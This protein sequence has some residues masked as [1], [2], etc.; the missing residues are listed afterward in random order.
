MRLR[1]L[2]T[3]Y[4]RNLPACRFCKVAALLLVFV[5]SSCQLHAQSSPNKSSGAVS[6]SG[7]VVNGVTHEP[8]GRALV[9]SM[10]E[11]YAALTDDHG[12]FELTLPQAFQV[13]FQVRRPGSFSGLKQRTE[14]TVLQ[15]GQSNVTLWLIPEGL[16]VGKVKF[17]NSEAGDKVQVQ[18]YSREV[19]NGFAQWTPI[20]RTTT[21]SNGEFRFA[22]LRAGDY[23]LFTLEELEQD[24][25]VNLPS[26]P[27]YGFPPRFF[28]AAKSFAAAETIHLQPGQTI[29]ADIS[30]ERQRYYDVRVPVTF[31]QPADW[32][33]SVSVFAQGHRG[34]GFALSYSPQQHAILGSLPNGSYEI[35]A[36]STGP[37]AATGVTHL[38]VDNGTVTA[39]LLSLTQN[40]SI[41]VN[42]HAE[43]SSA[44]NQNTPRPGT[45]SIPPAYVTLQ[46]AE[47]F[48]PTRNFPGYTAQSTPLRISGVRPG[49]YWVQVQPPFGYAAS[50]TSGSTDLLNTPLI[51]PFGVSVP[52]VDVTIRY[53][54]GEITGVFED[55]AGPQNDTHSSPKVVNRLTLGP[56]PQPN[57]DLY[58]ISLSSPGNSPGA[59]RSW[60]NGYPTWQNLPP[61]DYRILAFDTAREI[62]YRNAEVMRKYESLGEVVHVGA[63]EKVQVV[64]KPI[65]SQ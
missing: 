15:P 33:L 60:I 42:I 50:I 56:Y 40:P 27:V 34:P 38:V 46:S 2:Q 45:E 39:P 30:P 10:D 65:V 18:L 26:G 31:P 51:V 37:A 36:S 62:E 16:I 48:S 13:F 58:C 44:D 12:H 53:D 47:E 21:R 24:P 23:K 22:E 7:T 59:P 4:A 14:G 28:A 5:L 57:S 6:I 17:P 19:S 29:T 20:A 1:L 41:E 64:L 32:G 8:V 63:G 9:Y 52:P 54:S 11:R 43:M 55:S 61:G 25:V 49:R 35:E 3:D